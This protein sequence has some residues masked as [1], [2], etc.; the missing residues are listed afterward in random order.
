MAVISK[1]YTKVLAALLV[2]LGF[3]GTVIGCD[4]ARRWNG[5][6]AEYGVPSA[7]FKAKGVVVSETDNTPI[8]GIRAVLLEKDNYDFEENFYEIG[9]PVFS[10]NSGNFNVAG[11]S[12]PR[13]EIFYVKLTDVDG[14]ENG[15]FADKVVEADFRN[16]TFTGGSGNWYEG[17]TE[18]NLGTIKMTPDDNTPE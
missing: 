11:E 7:T 10:N 1:V 3:S 9:G 13:K 5:G 4:G 12:F 17:Q 6:Y 14:E 18:I 16:V 2:W 8:E 15:L